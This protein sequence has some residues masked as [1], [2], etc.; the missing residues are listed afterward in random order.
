M[1]AVLPIAFV[2]V[3]AAACSPS[4]SGE[5]A[6][7]VPT[8]RLSGTG[9]ATALLTG[10]LTYRAPCFVVTD[11]SG[12]SYELIWPKGFTAGREGDSVWV[13]GTDGKVW[14]Q[15]QLSFG[16]GYYEGDGAK[17][18]MGNVLNLP[19]ACNHDPFFLVGEV[20]AQ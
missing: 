17:A 10:R 3:V 15:P 1:K 12:T 16:G 6:I 19:E 7:M 5:P 2:V 9:E 20:R 14:N 11:E 18:L 8:Y 13:V 4:K